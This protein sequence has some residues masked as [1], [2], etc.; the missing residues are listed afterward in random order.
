MLPNSLYLVKIIFALPVSI[1]S[2][3]YFVVDAH[4]QINNPS[5]EE[6]P[7]F[8]D[9]LTIGDVSRQEVFE[10]INP[11]DGNFQSL[12]TTATIDLLDD[13]PAPEG[14]YNYS[15]NNP[16]SENFSSELEDF[17]GLTTDSLDAP[18]NS[19]FGATEGSGIKQTFTAQTGDRVQFGW[20]FLTNDGAAPFFGGPRDYAFVSIYPVSQGTGDI[21]DV[22]SNSVNSVGPVLTASGTTFARETGYTS[23]TSE[24]LDAG[25][26]VIG[27]GVVDGA[28]TDLTSALL[29]DQLQLVPTDSDLIPIEFYR[30]PSTPPPGGPGILTI[31]AITGT[32]GEGNPTDIPP[33]PG[34]PLSDTEP[35]SPVII[36]EIPE[37]QIGIEIGIM[38]GPTDPGISDI[39]TIIT[40][41]PFNFPNDGEIPQFPYYLPTTPDDPIFTV[42]DLGSGP[43]IGDNQNYFLDEPPGPIVTSRPS[44]TP[45]IDYI[46]V[47]DGDRE[48]FVSITPSSFL[49]STPGIEPFMLPGG[50]GATPIG[51]NFPISDG[52]TVPEHGSVVAL[53]TIAGL[54]MTAK[55]KQKK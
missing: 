40:V 27:L 6:E 35:A 38:Y 1:L 52:T 54:A 16:V 39:E 10:G 49:G 50:G 26:Y 51:T 17:L 33:A 41:L 44:G 15:G 18:V 46:E 24:P 4:A 36:G 48:Y 9:W 11:P 34:F 20:N 29:V 28:G 5:F 45:G 23:Y 25:E 8:A 31:E 30:N 43:P 13:R 55:C 22:L 14:T 53:F 47:S 42:I 3:G 21:S 37:D 7:E 32:D 19:A 2:I 12:L